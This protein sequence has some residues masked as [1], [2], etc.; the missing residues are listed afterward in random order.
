VKIAAVRWRHE[1]DA[2]PSANSQRISSSLIAEGHTGTSRQR[3]HPWE[4]R[5]AT[6]ASLLR[7]ASAGIRLS[8]HL[9]G[10]AGAEIIFEH[11]C[12]MALEGIVSKPIE[13]P[14][15]SDRCADWVKVK[16]PDAPAATR[17]MEW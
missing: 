14:Y 17:V 5:R 9:E 1:S 7:K 2:H 8:E 16:N 4:T 13:K 15:N 6:L 10:A 12:R 3:R 11:A